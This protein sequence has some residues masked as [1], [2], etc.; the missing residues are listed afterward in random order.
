[1]GG[2]RLRYRIP[3]RAALTA[4][5]GGL[6]MGYGARIAYGCNVGAFFS[7]VASTSL[8]GWLWIAAAL[9]GSWLGVRLIAPLSRRRML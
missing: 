5:A 4:L 9:P 7:G 3:A 6:A 2:F 8:H 1:V